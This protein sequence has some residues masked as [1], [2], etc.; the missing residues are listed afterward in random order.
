MSLNESGLPSEVV[1]EMI[2]FFLIVH[3]YEMGA[4]RE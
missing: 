2:E 1:S 3:S 4:T